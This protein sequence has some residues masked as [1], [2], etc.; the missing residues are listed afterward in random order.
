MKTVFFDIDTQFDFVYPVGALS[1]PG[2]ER[3]V[4][5][6]ARLN[7]FAAANGIPVVSTA[8]AHFED[9]PEFA[10]WPPHC[11]AGTM[12]QRK[13]EATLL[14]KRVV[15]PNREAEVD[16]S[17]AQQIILEKRH[18]DVFQTR[19]IH[20][21]LERLNA[22][23]FVVYGVVTEICVLRAALGLLKTG[24][25]VAVVTDAIETL[26]AANSAKALEEIRL[27]GGSFTTTAEICG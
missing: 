6:V 11:I 14:E 20:G 25:P 9:D 1:V 27:A 15:I 10:T 23:R 17:G 26:N 24:K 18:V 8:D 12:G 4:P 5:A 22:D 19:T 2:A 13:P 3:I 16:L 7:R 21:V